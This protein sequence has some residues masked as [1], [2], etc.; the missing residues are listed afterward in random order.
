M[1][2]DPRWTRTEPTEPELPGIV[3]DPFAFKTLVAWL[4]SRAPDEQYDY[5]Y[6]HRDCLLGR[7]FTDHGFCVFD[8]RST[9]ICVAY[10]GRLN[11]YASYVS[12]GLGW[13]KVPLPDNFNR[14]AYG[15]K[16][17]VAHAL[18]RARKI[19]REERK[20]DDM[21]KRL[22]RGSHRIC[23]RLIRMVEQGY[24]RN[25]EGFGFAGGSER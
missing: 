18:R 25:S 15:R 5:Y 12:A 23:A 24:T 17:T 22:Q 7:Y 2:L 6:G 11:D 4:E 14:V 20:L 9:E 3:Q 10:D 8:V 19:A 21:S 13:C 16:F 1:L